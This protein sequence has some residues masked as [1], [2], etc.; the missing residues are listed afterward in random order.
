MAKDTIKCESCD[1]DVH[2][3]KVHLDREHGPDS[4]SPMTLEE[5]QSTYPEAPLLSDR[6]KQRLAEKQA[7]ESLIR[8]I[9]TVD[10][11]APLAKLFGLEDA[12]GAKKGSGEDIMVTVS[13]AVGDEHLIPEYKSGYVYDIDVLKSILMALES[14]SPIYLYGHSGV[15]K[16]SLASQVCAATRR[17]RVRLNHS[18]NTQEA[19]ITG[20]WTVVPEQH[21]D[22]VINVTKFQLGPLPL[23]M[24]NG[25]TLL[26][27]EYDRAPPS[28]CSVYNAILEGDE[29]LHIPDAPPEY[30]YVDAHPDFR[31]IAT[32][33]T[34]GSGDDSGLYQATMT[35][36]AATI[37][38]FGLVLEI[39][40]L[41]VPQEIAVIRSTSRVKPSDAERLVNFAT[42]VR[43]RFPKDVSL[44][45]GPRPLIRAAKFGIMKGSM[46]KGIELAFTNRLPADE[47]KAVDDL[48]QRYFET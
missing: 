32:G 9:E 46:R 33:N 1:A 35:Q 21:G 2:V 11:K 39:G 23:C 40:Y 27:D 34:N 7:G 26:I 19:H 42:A 48:A 30:R 8:P 43:E 3:I 31:I 38:R 47:R 13:T 10:G 17:R 24:I 18:V 36:D 4:A 25:W 6:A 28:V 12:P 14:N 41:P 16:T 37:E 29:R 45:I 5:Y 20:Q 15:G 22:T 44:T